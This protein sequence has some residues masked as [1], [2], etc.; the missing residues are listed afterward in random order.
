MVLND[1][2]EPYAS[3]EPFNPPTSSPD[4]YSYP[5][6]LSELNAALGYTVDTSALPSP[7]PILGALFGNGKNRLEWELP[8]RFAEV[9]LNMNRKLTPDEVN[10][11]AYHW[12]KANAISSWGPPIG[13]LAG[14]YR[15]NATRTEFRHPLT[16]PMKSENGWFNGER[17]RILGKEILRGPP[18]RAL[19]HGFRTANYVFLNSMV[20]GLLVTTYAATVLVVGESR[21]P[22]LKDISG[23]RRYKRLAVEGPQAPR[24]SLPRKDAS[25]SSSS[26]A[27][28]AA[29]AAPAEEHDG[30]FSDDTQFGITYD[31]DNN[32]TNNNNTNTNTANESKTPAR[33]SRNAP[34]RPPV[35][36]TPRPYTPPAST[37]K[38]MS[39]QMASSSASSSSSPPD[40]FPFSPADPAPSAWE[41][42][43]REAESGES[44]WPARKE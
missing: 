35:V 13:V 34:Q 6:K 27:A 42:I 41:R 7:M 1:P 18:A 22:R 25:P 23:R 9:S 33:P 20:F 21:D 3:E 39:D 43:R 16:G 31:A 37:S 4:P 29:A 36:R 8:H 14:L 11:L 30:F 12:A 38:T 10:A 5:D 28:A 2:V 26:A 17:I 44:A 32:Q 40:D 15:A 19:L 24:G